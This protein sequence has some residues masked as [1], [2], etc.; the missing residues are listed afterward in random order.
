MLLLPDFEAE[1]WLKHT[2]SLK[3]RKRY[4]SVKKIVLTQKPLTIKEFSSFSITLF[5]FR[6]GHHDNNKNFINLLLMPHSK[7]MPSFKH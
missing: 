3:K 4:C 1:S 6:F 7:Y 5:Y 2:S